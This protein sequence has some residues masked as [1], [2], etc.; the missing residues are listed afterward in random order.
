MK[1]TP[2]G[3][4]NR[5]SRSRRT[6]PVQPREATIPI[7]EKRFIY[8]P[9]IERRVL[10]R[11]SPTSRVLDIGAAD[12]FAAI[13]MM[14][15]RGVSPKN[16]VM[17]D[18]LYHATPHVQSYFKGERRKIPKLSGDLHR[19]PLREGRMFDV[20]LAQSVLGLSG[21]FGAT[22][23]G[24]KEALRFRTEVE[25]TAG[26]KVSRDVSLQLKELAL[27]EMRGLDTLITQYLPRL[28][29]KGCLMTSGLT[30]TEVGLNGYADAGFE[31]AIRLRETFKHI[32]K[33][34]DVL[35]LGHELLITLKNR[36]EGGILPSLKY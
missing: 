28:T 10:D 6:T 20:I 27:L 9:E 21:G 3:K 16:I 1:P 29:R 15:R 23:S 14:S 19:P 17:M 25:R 18:P 11:L 35:W 22:P 33:H 12:G 26:K 5:P 8:H 2:R 13:E 31:G 34:V 30:F 32:R 4:R 24:R 7:F 36:K